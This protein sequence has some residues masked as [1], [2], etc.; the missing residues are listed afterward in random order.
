MLE[1]SLIFTA[2]GIWLLTGHEVR[3]THNR[4]LP[5][6]ALRRVG[7]IYTMIGVILVALSVRMMVLGTPDALDDAANARFFWLL[8][9]WIGVW[10]LCAVATIGVII[11]TVRFGTSTPTAK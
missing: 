1:I 10:G 5:R 2:F 3:V 4:S 6:P 7:A 9:S 11:W 8:S